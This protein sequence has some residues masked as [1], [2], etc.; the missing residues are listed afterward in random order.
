MKALKPCTNEEIVA[1][2]KFAALSLEERRRRVYENMAVNMPYSPITREFLAGKI[3][4][5]K[6]RGRKK[7]YDRTSADQKPSFKRQGST[8]RSKATQR[9]E[10][11]QPKFK[12]FETEG[13][14]R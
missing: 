6:K 1:Y 12:L 7:Q 4:L 2:Q 9:S 5:P 10:P 11:F 13:I 14:E 3:R 8:G